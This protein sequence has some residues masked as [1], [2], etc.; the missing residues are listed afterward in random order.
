MPNP[1]GNHSTLASRLAAVHYEAW[2]DYAMRSGEP[3]EVRSVMHN[4][5]WCV[6]V[7]DYELGSV[8]QHV[9]FA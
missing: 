9:H 3:L 8:R 2:H 6:E 5:E 4:G 7:V 1:E